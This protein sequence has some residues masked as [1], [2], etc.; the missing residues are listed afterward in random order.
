MIRDLVGTIDREKAEI[1]LFVT[2]TEPTKPMV[3]EA[4]APGLYESPHK[5]QKYPRIQI[6]TIEELMHGTKRPEY[7]DFS[8]G[9]T[10]K[11]AKKESSMTDEQEEMF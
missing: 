4:A 1:G 3:K 7:P 8:G 11:K 6:L 5:S 10:F 2:L 9:Q